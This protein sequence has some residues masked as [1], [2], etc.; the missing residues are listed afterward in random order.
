MDGVYIIDVN[1][2]FQKEPITNTVE[3][4]IQFVTTKAVFCKF[5][6]GSYKFIPQSIIRNWEELHHSDI[7]VYQCLNVD[8]WFCKRYKI[9]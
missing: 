1:N 8:E 5:K 7:E 9:I 2:Y 6:D 4:K 3:A